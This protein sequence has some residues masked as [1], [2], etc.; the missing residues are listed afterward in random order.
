[1]PKT[2]Y[3]ELI[4]GLLDDILSNSP[5]FASYKIA[6][7]AITREFL[8]RAEDGVVRINKNELCEISGLSFDT[9]RMVSKEL[10]ASERWE[11]VIGNGK[12]STTYR[13]LFMAGSENYT[14]HKEGDHQ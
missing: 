7:I 10:L 8:K 13:P 1:M 6:E 14:A 12:R 5:L 3:E 9:V 4:P 11:V 2:Q